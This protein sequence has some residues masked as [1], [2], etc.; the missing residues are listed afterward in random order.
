[1]ALARERAHVERFTFNGPCFDLQTYEGDEVILSGPA[2]TGKT[3]ACL[4]KLYNCATKYKGFR[5][6]IV[7]LTKASMS[8][9]ALVTF[10]RD[11]LGLNHPI[12]LN[13]PTRAGRLTYTFDN[14]SEI[15]VVGLDNPAKFLSSE[16]DIIYVVQAE[17]ILEDSWQTLMT[18]LRNGA[19]PYQQIIGD[20]NPSYPSHWIKKRSEGGSLTLWNTRHEDNPWLY[21]NG[22]WTDE[23]EK[24]LKT[25]DSLTGVLRKRYLYG[26]WA[27]QEGIIYEAYDDE[28]H[29]V[30][31]F[32]PPG[33]WP[34][35]AGIDPIGNYIACL[36]LAFDPADQALHVYREYCAPFGISTPGHVQAIKDLS[37]GETVWAWAGGGPSERQARIDWTT[38]GIELR[39]TGLTSV[40]AGIDRIIQLLQE[41]KLFI[42]DCCPRLLEEFA[43]YRRKKVRG[44]DTDDIEDKEIYHT[45]DA[46]RYA[47]GYITAG[48]TTSSVEVIPV[49]QRAY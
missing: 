18:R 17:E 13:G 41:Q 25:L 36:W 8:T 42:H 10:E 19:M 30:A 15:A 2:D 23:G 29:K 35:V 11:V 4:W 5:G 22:A 6:A 31:A 3:L 20:C 26:L 43:T 27:A 40:W 16:F 12:V 34:R 1:M 14:G 7:R 48:Y 47:V 32:M 9:T 38:A 45:L 37:K 21:R 44:Q 49:R 39:E 28:T 33:N 24:Y 46:L